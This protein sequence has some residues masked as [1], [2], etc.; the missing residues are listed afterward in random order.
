MTSTGPIAATADA[1]TLAAAATA[2][3]SASTIRTSARDSPERWS[4]PAP[5]A[6][7][8]TGS[9]RRRARPRR[10]RTRR[11]RRRAGRCGPRARRE[12]NDETAPSTPWASASGGSPAAI[13]PAAWASRIER[14]D[15]A[16][17]DL[18][19]LAQQ[20]R[21]GWRRRARRRAARS[22]RRGRALNRTL[23]SV[24][25]RIRV[26]GSAS[27]SIAAACALR[28]RR[29]IVRTSSANSS[30]LVGKYQ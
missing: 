25:W 5:S 21:R 17:V 1:S 10:R 22:S 6:G 7:V 2:E 13:S 29:R 27:G 24:P 12:V 19:A 16:Q 26:S 11:A 28:S 20:R 3:A 8:R 4:A 23:A 30:C 15:V 14:H 18:A 9:R